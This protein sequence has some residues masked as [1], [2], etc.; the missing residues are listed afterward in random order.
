MLV[1]DLIIELQKIDQELPVYLNDWSEGYD[2][3]QPVTSIEIAE[4]WSTSM[5]I[6]PL[7]VVLKPF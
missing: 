4:E 7:R 5:G 3:D 1:K 6:I 2:V